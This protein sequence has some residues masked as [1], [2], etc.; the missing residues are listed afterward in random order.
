M[1]K[2]VKVERQS[3]REI[4]GKQLLMLKL[5]QELHICFLKML[6]IENQTN[7]ILEPSNHPIYVHKLLSTHLLR[8]LRFAI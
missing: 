8:K 3:K 6:V 4:Y 2:M 1:S 5:K 7:K